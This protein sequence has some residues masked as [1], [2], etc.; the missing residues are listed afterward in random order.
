[1]YTSKLKIK[2]VFSERLKVSLLM[3]RLSDNQFRIA[4]PAAEKPAD[5]NC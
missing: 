1:M 2:N 5:H 4:G 3:A